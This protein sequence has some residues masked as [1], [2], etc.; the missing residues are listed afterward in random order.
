MNNVI[1]NGHK[2]TNLDITCGVPQGSILGPLLF[3]LYVNDIVN[4][5]ST[6]IPILFADDTNVFMSGTD[7]A[8]MCTLL[9]IE[10]Q[11]IV[12]WLN[13]NKLSLNV[14]KTH[15]ML[16][17]PHKKC[18]MKY[19]TN[20]L[21]DGHLITE[22]KNTKFLGVVL[23]NK[24]SWADH[25]NCIKKKI[26]KGIGIICKARKLISVKTLVS[27][28]YSFIYPYL[29]YCIEVWG[30]ACDYLLNP[31]YMLQK[32]IIRIIASVSY[33]SHTDS[34]FKR[35]NILTTKNMYVFSI[36][37]FMFKFH[38]NMVPN[39]FNCLFKHNRDVCSYSTRQ[40]HLLYIPLVKYELSKRILRYAGVVVWNKL[41]N[42]ISPYC[43]CSL[44]KSRLKKYLLLNQYQ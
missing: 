2:S 16:F 19:D 44:Y 27:L 25:I 12:M 13:S 7:I 29:L 10:L 33:L 40:S 41:F 42:K 20:I 38:H 21:L 17:R 14:S 37:L 31:L 36:A 32:K 24:L 23:D 1:Y 11:K 4:V 35:Y 26:S 9:N 22:T 30:N 3:L 34:L 6:L 8:D 15:Y 5:S 28:Y 39:I 43:T 18:K